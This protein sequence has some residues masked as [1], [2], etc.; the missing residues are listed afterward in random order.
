MDAPRRP[1]VRPVM[2]GAVVASFAFVLS[3]P[4]YDACVA[5][6]AVCQEHWGTVLVHV[7]FVEPVVSFA[8]YQR[9]LTHVHTTLAHTNNAHTRVVVV[10]PSV[11][12][13]QL[14]DPTGPWRPEAVTRSIAAAAASSPSSH[15][16]PG[17]PPAHA[18][19]PHATAAVTERVRHVVNGGT[20]D[21]LHNGHA[22]LLAASLS[23]ASE[24]LTVGITSD[25]MISSSNKALKELVQPYAVRRD[26][27]A[28]FCRLVNPSVAAKLYCID[29]AFGP[30]IVDAQ[31]ECIV[32]S[33]ETVGGGSAVNDRRSKGV[34]V[35]VALFFFAI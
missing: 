6:L 28:A 27:V 25:A 19:L 22:V 12:L 9:F 35:C 24:S 20:F 26:A 15:V 13:P 4:L 16:W 11:S 34:C 33:E 1:V 10:D 8:D 2:R 31:L 14:L 18:L 23:V 29:D 17:S 21:H 7:T 32:V 5:E 3:G 30:S